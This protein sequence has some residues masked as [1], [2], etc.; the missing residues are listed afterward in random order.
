MVQKL[1]VV[2][3]FDRTKS[4][5]VC[6]D[7]DTENDLSSQNCFTCDKVKP[8]YARIITPE[9]ERL[10]TEEYVSVVRNDYPTSPATPP[11]H[12]STLSEPGYY[13]TTYDAPAKSDIGAG[14]IFAII[15]II[16][17]LGI[18][19]FSVMYSNGVFDDSYY[20]STFDLSPYKEIMTEYTG[21]I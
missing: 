8:A 4:V 17:F 3:K 19:I 11:P 15:A 12:G 6:P 21:T 13:R 18:I 9:S 7:C 20:Y 14:A 5:W 2:L 1:N 10:E 16:I